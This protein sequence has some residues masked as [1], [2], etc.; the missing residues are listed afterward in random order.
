MFEY[1]IEKINEV[2]SYDDIVVLGT[3]GVLMHAKNILP[4]ENVEVINKTSVSNENQ[5]ENADKKTDKQPGEGTD[6]NAD[7]NPDKK[8]DEKTDEKTNEN[9]DKKPDEKT[10]EKTEGTGEGPQENPKRNEINDIMKQMDELNSKLTEKKNQLEKEENQQKKKEKQSSYNISNFFKKKK[11]G[12]AE[13]FDKDK[14]EDILTFEDGDYNIFTD[15]VQHFFEDDLVAIPATTFN[16]TKFDIQFNGNKWQQDFVNLAQV[17]YET[18]FCPDTFT[19]IN[20]EEDLNDE[21]GLFVMEVNDVLKNRTDI[22][23]SVSLVYYKKKLLLS[24]EKK[25]SN[26]RNVEFKHF[27]DEKKLKKNIKIPREKDHIKQQI[28]VLDEPTF[29]GVQEIVDKSNVDTVIIVVGGDKDPELKN[30]DEHIRW[31]RV[32]ASLS[33]ASASSEENNRVTYSGCADKEYFFEKNHDDNTVRTA[34]I[35]N[36][37]LQNLVLCVFDVRPESLVKGFDEEGPD[38]ERLD[39]S[40][41]GPEISNVQGPDGS[42]VETKLSNVSGAEGSNEQGINGSNVEGAEGSNEQGIKGS[43]VEGAEGSNEQGSEGSNEQGSEGS[44]EQGISG[45]NVETDLSN[46]QGTESSAKKGIDGSNVETDLSNE[47]GI[48]ESNVGPEISNDPN[49]STAPLPKK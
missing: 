41:V 5:D 20:D 24:E 34:S 32:E 4:I 47:Q 23:K 10:D 33:Q 12:G 22:K 35:E 36:A 18:E 30:I 37:I 45:S 15:V 9:A 8:P 48:N 27:N 39:L 11:T 49:K 16:F 21:L 25:Y 31:I 43:N 26:L 17:F 6:E 38:V 46:E 29:T 14:I 1:L 44:N 2:Q 19:G 7:K 13:T 3:L 42:N 40:N 28:V